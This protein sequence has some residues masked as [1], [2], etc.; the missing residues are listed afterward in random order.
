MAISREEQ[1]R[2][3]RRLA[4][5]ALGLVAVLLIV[6]GLFTVIGW[7]IRAVTAALDDSDRRESYADLLYG[8]VMFDTVPFDDVNTVDQS[9]FKQAAIWGC[10]YQIQKDGGSLDQ[11]ERDEETGCMIL[12]QLEVDAYLTNLLGPDYQIEEGSFQTSE[13]NY[14][15]SEEK[16]GYLVPV[17]GSVGLYTPEVESISTQSGKMYVTVGYIPTLASTTS[18]TLTTPTEPT[19]YMDY[20]FSRG[21]N[22]QWYLSA[23][24]ESDMQVAASSSSVASES[25]TVTSDP[26]ALV[27]SNL[28]S[29]VP[30]SDASSDSQPESEPSDESTDTSADD[31]TDESV[32]SDQ[33]GEDTSDESSS[34][35]SDA[36]SE[37]TDS[38]SDNGDSSDAEPEE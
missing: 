33:D 26:Q 20:V 35:D 7:A 19:K 21:E 24:Q 31:S 14:V 17:T 10:V 29:T 28:A 34:E 37:D 32:S 6:I 1:L 36:S 4:R 16:Q 27:E 23:L 13:M 11:Y 18:L 15:Y 5:Q 3:N 9:I 8:L 2:N 38:D 22:R 25:Q 30:G 12:P